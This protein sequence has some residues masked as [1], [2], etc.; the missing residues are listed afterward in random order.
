LDLLSHRSTPRVILLQLRRQIRPSSKL[1]WAVYYIMHVLMALLCLLL[2]AC[3]LLSN[4]NPLKLPCVLHTAFLAT[5]NHIITTCLFFRPSDVL[6]HIHSDASF[7][8]RPNSGSAAGGFHFL[9][10]TDPGFLNGPIF[11]HCTRIP[12]A[13]AAFSEAE[14]AGMFANFE[15]G[16]DERS[17]LESLGYSQPPTTTHCDNLCAP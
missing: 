8:N 1:L 13:C 17:M 5:P 15:I 10:T 9:G 7:L 16:S 12:V 6:L 2:H 14:Y 11:C 4:L 3:Y